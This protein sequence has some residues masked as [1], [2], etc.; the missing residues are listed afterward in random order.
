MW[1]NRSA[2]DPLRCQRVATSLL[3]NLCFML[4]Y[5]K[6]N[7][8]A[9]PSHG[10]SMKRMAPYSSSVGQTQGRAPTSSLFHFCGKPTAELVVS[11]NHGLTLLTFKACALGAESLRR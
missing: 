4:F 10:I 5:E 7:A 9:P 2:S 1:L 3:L 11:K 6:L 8:K